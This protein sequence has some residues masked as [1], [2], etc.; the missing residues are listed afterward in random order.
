[1]D[2]PVTGS[3]MPPGRIRDSPGSMRTGRRCATSA[4]CS[5]PPSSPGPTGWMR[6]AEGETGWHSGAIG[7][8]VTRAELAAGDAFLQPPTHHRGQVH[9]M[10]TAA[11][12]KPDDTDLI[13]MADDAAEPVDAALRTNLGDCFEQGDFDEDDAVG[14]R[15]GRGDSDRR[16]AQA[17]AVRAEWGPSSGCS[18]TAPASRSPA[19][20]PA[21]RSSPSGWSIS[22]CRAIRTAAA[23]RPSLARR[24]SA[25]AKPSADVLELPRPLPAA[26]GDASLR[27][28]RCRRST[29]PK[30]SGHGEDRAALQAVG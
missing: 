14:G 23:R 9:A 29:P 3:A 6:L 17:F 24:A 5:T 25:R 1:M 4:A 11:G 19:C 28:G 20:R 2:A 18:G 7:R 26:D 13:F 8:H 10:L 21:R 16:E 15:S 27:M 12:A 22:T 30:G